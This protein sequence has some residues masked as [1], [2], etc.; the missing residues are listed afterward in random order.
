MRPYKTGQKPCTVYFHSVDRITRNPCRRKFT[1]E[2]FIR[3]PNCELHISQST[4]V[5]LFKRE[6]RPKYKGLNKLTALQTVNCVNWRFTCGSSNYVVLRDARVVQILDSKLNFNQTY[7]VGKSRHLRH[8]IIV[9]RRGK[10]RLT[11]CR[12]TVLPKWSGW[13]FL[14]AEYTFIRI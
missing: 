12:R 14:F 10:Q 9:C 8:W 6:E 3:L 1:L 5:E 4:W 13:N 2:E 11:Q 7:R